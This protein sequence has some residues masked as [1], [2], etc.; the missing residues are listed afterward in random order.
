MNNVLRKKVILC[1]LDSDPKSADE[2][3]GEIDESLA[4]VA[5][6]LTALV[7]EN[8]CETVSQDE[9][10][11]YVVRKD[12]E[13]FAQLVKEFLS[14][15]EE[16]N[17]ETEQFISSNYYL[18]RIDNQLVDYVLKRFY[19]DTVYQI[20]DEE[21]TRRILL[22]SPSALN[23]ALHTDTTSF[24]ESWTSLN[25]LN[26]SDET[27]NWSIQI[28]CSTF[29]TRL[30][31]KLIAD[32]KVY[33][34]LYA[35]LQIKVAKI[36]IQVGLATP[37]E[38]YVEAGRGL[39]Y[40]FYKTEEGLQPGQWVSVV[41]PID[42]SDDGLAR[43]HLGEFQ[44]ALECFDTALNAVED[45]IQKAIVL[46]NKG[47][48]FLQFKQ[49]NKAIE[50]FDEGIVLDP[51]DEIPEL[52]ENKQIA[53]E[54]L[55]RATDADNLAEPTQIRFVQ[56]YPIPFEETLFYEFKEIKEGS[57]PVN[58]IIKHSN[59]YAVAFLN[60]EGG[61]IFWGVRDSNRITTGVIL[62]EQQRNETRTKVSEKLG[63]I[64]P[65]ISPE[66]WQLEFH[67]VDDLQGEIVEDLWVI[68]LV[69]P[70][71]QERDVFY[72]G[73][74]DLFVKTE[75]GRQKLRGQQITEF[76]LRHLQNDTETD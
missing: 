11:Q 42:Y 71:P 32:V 8:I 2:I 3:A 74:S 58:P 4:T 19:L 25:Q 7:S 29:E 47:L 5:D 68:E 54:Y 44:A 26:P 59:E 72:T 22:A 76:I 73:S 49:Y 69:I 48:A 16:H 35:K 67:N 55:A 63:A 12:I 57:N 6:Q 24:H 14:N 40:A 46:N 41:N 70:P 34:S 45:P 15:P 65:S 13:T 56:G 64:Q 17:R 33:S 43:L 18:T 66:D 52:C 37:H 27:R 62:N 30:L 10:S 61:R 51:E 31:E 28:L 50:C 21:R 53:E 23:F 1:L 9:I 39:S 36:S 60:R 75:G 20:D 38:K